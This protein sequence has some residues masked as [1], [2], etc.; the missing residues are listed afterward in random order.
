MLRAVGLLINKAVRN[1]GDD[2]FVGHLSAYDFLVVTTPR[3]IQVL[4]E[5]IL[6]RLENSFGYFYPHQDRER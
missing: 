1:F 2:D 6:S 5:T 4:N 3:K